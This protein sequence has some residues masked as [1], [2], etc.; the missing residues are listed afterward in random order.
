MIGA[1]MAES[2][3]RS[4]GFALDRGGSAA[5]FRVQREVV[6][7]NAAYGTNPVFG[8]VF[9]G[10]SRSDAAVGIAHSWVVDVAAYVA[11]VLVHEFL[12]SRTGRTMRLGGPTNNARL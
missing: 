10:S 9:E 8:D 3:E 6:L 11:D 7:A 4:R 2:F 12:Y 1:P 5:L